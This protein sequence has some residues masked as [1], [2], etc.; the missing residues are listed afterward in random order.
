MGVGCRS[1]F[2][3]PCRQLRRRGGFTLIELMIIVAIMG[4]LA[5]IAV[6]ELVK[7]VA[8]SR[9]KAATA[10]L[11]ADLAYARAEARKRSTRVG[12]ARPND[13]WQGGWLV[14]IDADRNG[15]DGDDEVLKSVGKP[16]YGSTVSGG[17]VTSSASAVKMCARLRAGGNPAENDIDAVVFGGDGA[18]RVYL[19]NDLRSDNVEGLGITALG[20]GDYGG[21]RAIF[22]GPTG[23]VSVQVK[24]EAADRCT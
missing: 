11:V 2:D 24:V 10:D 21:S 15:Y 13:L 12:V 9:V 6:P 17:A 23:R 7:M 3:L 19:G 1:F 4:I 5:A 20:H 8:S 22:F 14:F 16:L 18:V